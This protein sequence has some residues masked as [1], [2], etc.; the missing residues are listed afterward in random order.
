MIVRVGTVTNVYPSE[1]KVR[2]LYQDRNE[3]SVK[4]P[5]LAWEYKMPAVGA[6]VVTLHMEGRSSGFVLGEYWNDTNQPP[7]VNTYSRGPKPS[8]VKQ[9]GSDSYL[10]CVSGQLIFYSPEIVFQSDAGT[11]TMEELMALFNRVTDLEN[12]MSRQEG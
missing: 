6:A 11:V 12:R 8:Y 1:G 2:V 9:L 7:V 4:L 10:Q 3:T 5:L